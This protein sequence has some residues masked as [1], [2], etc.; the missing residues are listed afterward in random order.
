VQEIF[1]LSGKK[2]D[3]FLLLLPRSPK[4]KGL[5]DMEDMEDMEDTQDTQDT[6]EPAQGFLQSRKNYHFLLIEK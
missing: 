4:W 2:S 6:E 1:Q 5:Q 3:F